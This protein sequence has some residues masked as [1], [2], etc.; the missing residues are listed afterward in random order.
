MHAFC[1]KLQQE[2]PGTRVH[3]IGHSFGCIVVSSILGGPGGTTR[4]PRAVESLFLI[5][6][7]VSLWAFADYIDAVRKPGYFNA[8][9]RGPAVRGPIVTTRSKR[10]GAVGKLYPLA[11]G[12]V[13]QVSYDEQLPIFGGIGT[14]GA[15]GLK[16]AE[17]VVMR[18]ASERYA[19]R[20]GGIYNLEG[21]EYIGGHS[22]IDSPEVAHA[23]W[24]AVR[25]GAGK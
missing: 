6:G 1:T 3:L 18:R 8:M 19:F 12:I 15:Q 25:T 24:E 16:E 2:C 13:G 4:L 5:Q 7:A 23:I 17:D 10:D 21:T 20:P 9:I 14:W 11:V 22:L